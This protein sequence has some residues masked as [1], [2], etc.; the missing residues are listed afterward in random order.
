MVFGGE[1]NKVIKSG[2]ENLFA[3]NTVPLQ[4]AVSMMP[5]SK[6]LGTES[7]SNQAVDIPYIVYRSA[8]LKKLEM[9][10]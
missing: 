7:A 8:H 3:A 5:Q 4:T 10:A 6:T 1:N 9:F 2:L